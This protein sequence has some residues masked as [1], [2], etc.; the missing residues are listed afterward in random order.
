MRHFEPICDPSLGNDIWQ[1][2]ASDLLNLILQSQLFLLQALNL[3]KID[4]PC[5]HQP[6]DLLVSFFVLELQ[7]G[8]LF[9]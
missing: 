2:I 6:V 3:Q 8:E 7:S 5:V 9:F 1:D 4:G